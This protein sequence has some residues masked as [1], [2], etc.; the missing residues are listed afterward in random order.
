[1]PDTFLSALWTLTQS[2]KLPCEVGT[3]ITSIY[4]GGNLGTGGK[5]T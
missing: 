4:R 5:V 2:S 1:M 3:I